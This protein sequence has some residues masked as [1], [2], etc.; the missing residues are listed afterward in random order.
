MARVWP[1]RKLIVLARGAEALLAA[2]SVKYPAAAAFDTVTLRETAAASDGIPHEERVTGKRR[3]D[4]A[5]RI[6]APKAPAS[7][8]VSA[9]RHGER[10]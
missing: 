5:G 2:K 9:T 10:A 3:S 7:A 8:R 4:E 1:E 6:G